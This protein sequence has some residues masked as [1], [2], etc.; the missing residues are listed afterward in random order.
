M[1]GLDKYLT[2]PFDNGY[3]LWC[4]T[5]WTLV[6]DIEVTL[7]PPPTQDEI[8][9]YWD[10]FFEPLTIKLSTC[11]TLPSGGCAP[12]FAATV[13][14]SRWRILNSQFQFLLPILKNK[15]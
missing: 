5:V 11:G 14:C 8:N 1:E 6:G 7:I 15:Q 13:I 4:D 3:Q 9:D 12:S 10:N 2:T